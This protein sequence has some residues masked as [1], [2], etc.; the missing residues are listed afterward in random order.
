M[1]DEL[2]APVQTSTSPAWHTSM[3]QYLL[4]GAGLLKPIARRLE[5][6]IPMGWARSLYWMMMSRQI[7]SRND[8]IFLEQTIVPLITGLDMRHVL[9]VGCRPYTRHYPKAFASHG[10]TLWTMDIDPDAE[11]FGHANHHCTED[12]LK[13]S[14]TTFPVVFDAV[15][16][17]GVIGYG[18]NEP[19]E[20]DA[21]FQAFG[22]TMPTG[23]LLVVGWNTDRSIDPLTLPSAR[24]LFCECSVVEGRSRITFDALTHVYDFLTRS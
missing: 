1:R 21:A 17:N 12:V 3:I 6:F 14:N 24:T 2:V 11:R 16:V 18:V 23:S 8:R 9:F 19:G 5:R 22:R 15:I 4:H 7:L 10:L 20:I 13:L